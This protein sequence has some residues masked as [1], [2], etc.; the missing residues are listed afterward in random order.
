VWKILCDQAAVDGLAG[1]LRGAGCEVDVWA[2]PQSPEQKRE[3]MGLLGVQKEDFV[4][5]TALCAECSF[6]TPDG[7]NCG[8]EEWDFAFAATMLER[9]S[10]AVGDLRGCPE[11]IPLKFRDFVSDDG[12]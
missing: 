1:M 9:H 11:G 7:E 5:R 12:G 3:R 6:F 10:K 4:F 2:E 8:L